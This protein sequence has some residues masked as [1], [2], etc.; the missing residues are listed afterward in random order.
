MRRESRFGDH[1]HDL[2]VAEFRRLGDRLRV[3]DGSHRGVVCDGIGADGRL[4]RPVDQRGQSHRL[5][6]PF[7]MTAL[8]SH[9]RIVLSTSGS[10]GS[11]A[12]T[13]HRPERDDHPCLCD[14]VP[15]RGGRFV[16]LKTPM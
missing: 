4:S 15:Q 10:S 7:R 14:R 8:P 9:T 3:S 5:W 13:E 2:L 11:R 6:P 12:R 1:I 16:P